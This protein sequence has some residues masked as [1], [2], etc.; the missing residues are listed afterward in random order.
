MTRGGRDQDGVYRRSIG[1]FIDKQEGV[2]LGEKKGDE[3]M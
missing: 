3:H 2:F 1:V